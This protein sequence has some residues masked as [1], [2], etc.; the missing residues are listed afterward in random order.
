MG[1]S[2]EASLI[3]NT[4]CNAKNAAASCLLALAD[5]NDL[6]SLRR[7]LLNHR[8]ILSERFV[9]VDFPKVLLPGF[10]WCLER[11]KSISRPEYVMPF[12]ELIAPHKYGHQTV[13]KCPQYSST[14]DY[15]YD[16]DPIRKNTTDSPAK[17]FT[18][19]PSRCFQNG[20]ILPSVLESIRHETTL[21]EGQAQ[22]LCD[23]LCRELA[24]TQGPPG[25]GKTFLGVA[26]VKTLL[27]SREE[28]NSRPIVVVC[29]T[30][31]ALDSFLD[32]LR[33]AGLTRF[34]RLGR[35]SK[36]QWTTAHS[37]VAL[38]RRARRPAGQTKQWVFARSQV[39]GILR[40]LGR[41]PSE[42]IS[43]GLLICWVRTMG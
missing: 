34:A 31:H 26:L 2:Y 24:F 38:S 22:A 42:L 32:G 30:N 17:K 14:D 19:D 10:S 23:S 27:A 13:N 33:S 9:L 41:S 40:P 6:A 28:A 20:Q 3:P 39:D 35:G 15:A 25:T 12:S 37:I 18:L 36:E 4:T 43:L 1:T 16:L 7:L 21:D 11:L 8:K 29:M 5:P